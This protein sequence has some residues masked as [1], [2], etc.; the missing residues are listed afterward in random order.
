[1]KNLTIGIIGTGFGKVIG[2]VWRALDPDCKLYLNGHDPEKTKR[3]AREIGAA[4]TYATWQELIG[5]PKIDVV[6]I[7]SPNHLHKAMFEA[8][9]RAK[10]HILLEKPAAL[11]AADVADMRRLVKGYPRLIAINHEARFHPVVGYLRNLIE[12]GLL[13]TILTVRIGTHLNLFSSP[14]Y[15]GSWYNYR[16]HGGGQ[17]NAIGTHQIDLARHLLGM[18]E[19][20]GGSVQTK[21]FQ[22]PRFARPVDA[23]SQFA[24]QFITEEGASIDM[25]SDTYCFGYKDLLIEVIGSQGIALY[26]DTQGLRTSFA[27]DQPLELIAVDDPLRH[28]KYGNSLLT[29]SMKFAAKGFID[30]VRRNQ[31]DPRFCT[32]EMAYQNLAILEKY[33]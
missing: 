22:D 17:L 27:N 13:G 19:I 5:D 7:A 25:F 28:I 20:V 4:G 3:I 2:Q 31:L 23:E 1:M 26:S 11:S 12:E 6:V 24:A 15:Q 21:R 16:E 8:A 10:K 9:V 30:S 14:D 32:L 29:K 33:A 18:P